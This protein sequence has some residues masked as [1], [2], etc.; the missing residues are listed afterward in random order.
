MATLEEPKT[1]LSERTEALGLKST[2][3]DLKRAFRDLTG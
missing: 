2:Y 1:K 3:D